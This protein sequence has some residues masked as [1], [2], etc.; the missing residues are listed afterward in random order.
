MCRPGMCTDYHSTGT[1]R[2][3]TTWLEIALSWFWKNTALLRFKTVFSHFSASAA[4]TE[5]AGWSR[6]RQWD[7]GSGLS[8]LGQEASCNYQSAKPFRYSV[9]TYTAQVVRKK[10]SE[11]V[12][13]ILL[14]YI[15]IYFPLLVSVSQL[16][17]AWKGDLWSKLS[18]DFWWSYLWNARTTVLNDLC[19]PCEAR[20]YSK[21]A[22]LH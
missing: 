13:F 7:T 14:M 17:T 18:H 20:I 6:T 1:T 16:W 8:E 15:H 10:M 5:P 9:S 22:E 2:T 4:L 11:S 21:K 3:W 12:R 19:I